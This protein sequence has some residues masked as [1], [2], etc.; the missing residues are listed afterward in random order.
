MYD[1]TNLVS[2]QK[3]RQ[4][5][6]QFVKEDKRIPMFVVGNKIQEPN[7]KVTQSMV[8]ELC[9][10]IGDKCF[11]TFVDAKHDENIAGCINLILSVIFHGE[12]PFQRSVKSARTGE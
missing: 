4:H 5:I 6:E 9:E 7:R 8:T 3:I 2:F 10:S 12:A 11:Y 1:V